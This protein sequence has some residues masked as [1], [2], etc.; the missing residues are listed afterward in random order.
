[1]PTSSPAQTTRQRVYAMMF[2]LYN[3][4]P[5][6]DNL[7]AYL[8]ANCDYAVFGYE[9][10]PTTGRPHLQGYLHWPNKRWYNTPGGNTEFRELFPQVHDELPNGTAEANRKYCLKI[11]PG[12]VPNEKFEEFGTIPSQGKRTDW[13]QAITQ[14]STGEDIINVLEDQPHLIPCVRALERVKQLTMKARPII[15]PDVYVL[16]GQPGSGKTRWAYDNYPELYSK[17]NGQWWDGY[18]GQET[19]LLDDFYGD[20]EYSLL[21]KVCDRYPL[22]VPVK[23]GFV[24]ANWKRVIITSNQRPEQWYPGHY[25][26]SA[27]NR[28]V[29]NFYIDS[30]P[31]ADE[32]EHAQEGEPIQETQVRTTSPDETPR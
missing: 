6:L 25:D 2:T 13:R 7:R 9:I 20:V 5:L 8:R 23:G 31:N 1:M 30:I 21:L 15:K 22:Q 10:C 24:Q 26:L 11:R 29:N 18:Q 3:Y 16:V 19:I 28:R 14:I 12:D 32:K 17:P 27:F 4:E